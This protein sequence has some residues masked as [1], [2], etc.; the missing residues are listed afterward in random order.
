VSQLNASDLFAIRAT[1]ALIEVNRFEQRVRGLVLSHLRALQAE[2][3]KEIIGADIEGAVRDE[4]KQERLER[5]HRDVT[6][7]L[8]REMSGARKIL[9]RELVDLSELM[10]EVAVDALNVVFTV[11][12][13]K[14]TLTRGELRALVDDDVVLGAP[15]KEWWSERSEDTRR[16]F[17]REMRVG[18]S[19]GE[20][21][22]QLIARV[23]GKPTGGMTTVTLP[24]GSVA[25]VR[26]YAGG[27]LDVSYSAVEALVR[28]STASVSNIT[29]LETYRQNGDVVKGIEAI[30]TLDSRTSDI[31]MARTGSA[32]DL[33][34]KPF[35]ES[36]TQEP[37]P[38][39]PPWHF[40]CRTVLGPVM[41]SWDELLEEAGQER[42]GLL[43]TVP[44]SRRAAFDGQIANNVRTFDD[45]LKQRGDAF[46]K[47]KLGAARF[48]LWKSGK[49]TTS[50]LIDPAGNPRTLS[51]IREALGLAG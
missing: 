28:N 3:A 27:L 21:N 44:T 29:L 13:A 22:E 12:I 48:E 1:D 23:R 10:H 17:I 49:M 38:G 24:D 40:R 39:P 9:T 6:V 50:Q 19:R 20:T 33:E 35:P 11:D 43:G 15:S 7:I 34:G 37:F 16:A 2:L 8:N 31:C 32:W 26:E 42:R 36:S 51:E 30:T 5:L 14:V 45:W 41:K 18:I 25:K 4:T 47:K 46:A